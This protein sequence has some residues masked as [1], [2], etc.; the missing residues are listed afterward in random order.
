MAR[1]IKQDYNSANIPAVI[2]I[3][4]EGATKKAACDL[5]GIAYNTKRLQDIIDKYI[6]DKEYDAARRKAKRGT[7]IEG[8][9][10]VNII[11]SYLIYNASIDT[12]SKKYHR[13]TAAIKSVLYRSGAMLKAQETPNPLR[14]S[15]LPEESILGED[16][17]FE[18]KQLVWV[19][20]YQC[21]GEVRKNFGNGVYRVYLLDPGYHRN[22]TFNWYDLGNLKHLEALGVNLKELSGGYMRQEEIIEIMSESL[23][24]AR[25]KVRK[26]D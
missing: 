11:E 19:A 12:L 22:V 5:L 14:P 26:D 17:E 16:E 21:V 1:G 20:G 2:K 13:P 4:E 24:K 9:E 18:L 3:L 23:R 8:D 10:L 6:S 25:M 7:A 15:E